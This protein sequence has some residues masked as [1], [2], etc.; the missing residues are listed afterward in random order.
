MKGG[1]KL[2]VTLLEAQASPLGTI[3]L[4]LELWDAG[5]QAAVVFLDLV[6]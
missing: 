6:L 4:L 5:T 2:T 1:G 3:H